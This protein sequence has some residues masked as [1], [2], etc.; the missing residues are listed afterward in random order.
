MRFAAKRWP[1]LLPT[2]VEV[3]QNLEWT[4]DG[5]GRFIMRRDAYGVERT[6]ELGVD[7]FEVIV[8]WLRDVH[9][10]RCLAKCG[11]VMK[12]LHR[13]DAGDDVAQG[14]V[15]PGP[16]S[17]CLATFEGHKWAW[18][19]AKDTTARHCALVT[20][21]SYW[22]KRRKLPAAERPALRCLCGLQE[23]SRPHLMWCCSALQACR[24][25]IVMPVNRLEERLLAKEVPEWPRPPP[26]LDYDGFV[27]DLAVVLQGGLSSEGTVVVATDG[28]V[29]DGV[30]ALA[31]V[32]EG[33]QGVFTLGIAAEDQSSH[34]A[35]VEALLAVTRALRRTTATGHVHIL[36]DCQSALRAVQ[37]GGMGGG[38]APLLARR[39]RQL[40]EE[41]SERLYIHWWWIP[42]H[43]KLAP[44]SWRCPP[45]GEMRARALNARADRAARHRAA[46]RA[47][48]SDLQ[49]CSQ[50]RLAATV[51]EKGVLAAF[52]S[53]AS[54][55]ADA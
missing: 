52:G 23:P 14:L 41:V 26:V 54:R 51:W 21:C 49:R 7:S 50:L 5:Q 28:S 11:R 47:N 48:G 12:Q 27:D 37:G 24:T 13:G 53:I 43:G 29:I 33:D 19:Q 16:P 22:H 17:D 42:S 20:G 30:S 32:L 39:S 45:C 1:A 8:E 9:R 2:T 4:W 25:D 38:K 3:L 34:R 55:W 18:R 6:F 10:R 44:A 31:V 40:L 35:E 15:L 36:S 46:T